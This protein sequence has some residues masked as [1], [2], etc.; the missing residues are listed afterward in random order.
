MDRVKYSRAAIEERVPDRTTREVVEDDVYYVES[1]T[2]RERRQYLLLT[3]SETLGVLLM[4][5]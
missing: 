5:R 4:H 2:M 3:P 1:S